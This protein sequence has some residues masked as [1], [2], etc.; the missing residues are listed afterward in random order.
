M[1]RLARMMIEISRTDDESAITSG[2]EYIH[3]RACYFEWS[4]SDDS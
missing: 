4:D 2:R 3:H 1:D